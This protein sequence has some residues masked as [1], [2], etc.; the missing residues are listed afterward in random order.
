MTITTE[1][2]TDNR[3]DSEIYLDQVQQ[4]AALQTEIAACRE[5]IAILTGTHPL[6]KVY[7]CGK[8]W[9]AEYRGKTGHLK[10]EGN[11][12]ADA[13]LQAVKGWQ[14]RITE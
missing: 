12:T 6:F 13:A 5:Q 9:V 3:N 10:L 11:P 14:E 4:I 1:P 7:K 8:A 2:E